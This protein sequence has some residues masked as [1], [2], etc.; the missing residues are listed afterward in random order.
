M[1]IG[2]SQYILI[3]RNPC[4]IYTLTMENEKDKLRKQVYSPLQKNNRIPRDKPIEAEETKKRWQG[5]TEELYKKD[6]DPD[7]HDGVINHLEPDILECKVKWVLGRITR[8]KARG[9]GEF[10]LS[11]FKSS[12]MML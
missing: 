10:Q 9:G 2:K 4:H 8:N 7:K 11:Y 3:H 12:K 6:N 1:K 5:S